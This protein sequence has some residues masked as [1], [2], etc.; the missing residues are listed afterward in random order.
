MSAFICRIK[1][2]NTT[3]GSRA[4]QLCSIDVGSKIVHRSAIHLRCTCTCRCHAN[5]E[6]GDQNLVFDRKIKGIN[7]FFYLSSAVSNVTIIFQKL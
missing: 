5:G 3:P 4:N 2:R 7:I 6:I 1:H